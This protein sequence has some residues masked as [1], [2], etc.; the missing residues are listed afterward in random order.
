MNK[1]RVL[2]VLV[3]LAITLVAAGCGGGGGARSVEIDKD[4]VGITSTLNNFIAAA[5]SGDKATLQSLLASPSESY[6]IV[7]D[8]GVD[9]TDPDDNQSYEF[10]VNPDL[11]A[12]TSAEQAYVYAYYILHSGEPLWLYFNMV[13]EEGRW[14]I[15]EMKEKAPEAG[16]YVQ[17]IEPTPI[18]PV[19]PSEF[20]VASYNPMDSNIDKIYAIENDAGIVSS[21]RLI[22][23][24]TEPWLDSETGITFA[25]LIEMYEEPDGASY[26]GFVPSGLIPNQT[27][28]RNSLP[29]AISRSVA[30]KLRSNRFSLRGQLD[31]PNVSVYYGYDSSGAMWIKLVDSASIVLFNN[32]SPIK[33]FEPSHPYG[34]TRTISFPYEVGGL[35][36]SSTITINIGFTKS[37]S[38]PL[39]DY[40]VVPV[41]FTDIDDETGEGSKWTEYLVPVVGEVGYDEYETVTS[42]TPVEKDRLLTRFNGDRSLNERNDP[43]ITNANTN[44]GTYNVGDPITAMQVNV[45][46]GA[47]PYMFRW[48][49]AGPTLYNLPGVTVSPTGLLQGTAQ[50][51]GAGDIVEGKLEVVDKYGRYSVK[52]FSYESLT[53]DVVGSPISFSPA[54]HA[55]LPV[56]GSVGE[57]YFIM[58]NGVSVLYNDPSY[59]P[60]VIERISP[61]DQ[62]SFNAIADVSVFSDLDGYAK[63]SVY[64]LGEGTVTFRAVAADGSYVSDNVTISFIAP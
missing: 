8:F 33:L 57:E 29:R 32:N 61:S 47:S 53:G 58:I 62:A 37:F 11:I 35:T 19:T 64:G 18:T 14:V 40:T 41:T 48:Y 16:G 56:G 5:R 22:T 34:T 12:Q 36:F 1:L 43:I 51:S 15:E 6:L 3:I 46:G 13:R 17:P 49:L 10:Y 38:T 44:L 20:V 7:K 63:L 21:T 59:T 55:S 23:S 60:F 39:Q 27:S 45:S 54:V 52:I 42:T 31:D 50:G 9:I 26:Q 28:L 25:E 24:Y 4:V 2:S 30:S